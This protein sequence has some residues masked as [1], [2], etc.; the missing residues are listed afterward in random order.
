M[1]EVGVYLS[2]IAGCFAGIAFIVHKIIQEEK[3]KKE[4]LAFQKAF[5]AISNRKGCPNCGCLPCQCGS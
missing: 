2:V 3:E 4:K 5:S 1:V